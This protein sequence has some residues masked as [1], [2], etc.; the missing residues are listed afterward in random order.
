MLGKEPSVYE[1]FTSFSNLIKLRL[2]EQAIDRHCDDQVILVLNMQESCTS[3]VLLH[4]LL[5]DMLQ[6]IESYSVDFFN[7]VIDESKEKVWGEIQVRT[8]HKVRGHLILKSAFYQK[9]DG[10]LIKKLKIYFGE[11]QP[12]VD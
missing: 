2:V 10:G 6:K 1:G 5:N 3:K 7:V 11:F 9:W 12:V 8:N 4:V